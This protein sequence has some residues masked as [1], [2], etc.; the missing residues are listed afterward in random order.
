M[1]NAVIFDM[2]GTLIDTEKHLVECWKQAA[3][4]AGFPFEREHGL[5][6]RSLA[7]AFAG[8]LLQS[9]FGESFDYEKIRARRKELMEERLSKEGI[10]RKSGAEELLIYLREQG[11]KCAVATAT[12][13]E[14]ASRY[15]K[16]VGLFTY[17]DQIIC[18]TMVK[19]GKPMPDVY[20]YACEELGELP[21]HCIAVEDSP[22]GALSAIRAGLSTIF[23]IDQSGP[24]EEIRNSLR[25]VVASLDEIKDIIS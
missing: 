21:E 15:L 19:Q 22:N 25:G 20:L 9:I 12:D 8:P 6:I 5:M 11:I 16:Q 14:R 24:S 2:D 4:E 23:V 18:A 7:A 1:I 3:R 17:F 10:E 13:Y